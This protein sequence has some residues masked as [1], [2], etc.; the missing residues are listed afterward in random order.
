MK[1]AGASRS[2]NVATSQCHDATTSRRW[3]NHYK[4]Q[5]AVTSRRLNVVTSQRRDVA[6]SRRQSEIYPPSLKAK[7]VQKRRHR[8]TYGLGHGNQNGSYI[9]LEEEPVICIVSSFWTIELMF[10]LSRISIFLVSMF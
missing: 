4:S 9:D 10:Y 5:Q 8:E 3:V 6:T 1:L 7:G 2:S